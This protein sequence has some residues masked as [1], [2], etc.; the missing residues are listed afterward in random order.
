MTRRRGNSGIYRRPRVGGDVTESYQSRR[1]T[2]PRSPSGSLR[3][4]PRLKVRSR[5]ILSNRRFRPDEPDGEQQSRS[6]FCSCQSFLRR[7][8]ADG[9][10][11]P[12]GLT[13]H[14]NGPCRINLLQPLNGTRN[15]VLNHGIVVIAGFDFNVFDL[16]IVSARLFD[17]TL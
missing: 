6:C 15:A 1:R 12:G 9:M 2:S 14:F 7:H 10:F 16:L 4:N 3:R 17:K 13:L 5:W 11:L 8:E